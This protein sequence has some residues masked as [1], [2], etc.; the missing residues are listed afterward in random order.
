MRGPH[1]VSREILIDGEMRCGGWGQTWRYYERT[2]EQ[3]SVKM[4]VFGRL[5]PKTSEN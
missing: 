2:S 5:R 3:R 1:I 4:L